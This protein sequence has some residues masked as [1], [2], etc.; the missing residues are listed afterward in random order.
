MRFLCCWDVLFIWSERVHKLL[1]WV[2]RST[3]GEYGVDVRWPLRGRLV[4][5]SRRHEL[6]QLRIT[7]DAAVALRPRRA[8]HPVQRVRRALQEG[9]GAGRRR[10]GRARRRERRRGRGR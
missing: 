6:S 7:A 5:R 1:C 4:G 3:R 10:V 2:L 8:A 9:A